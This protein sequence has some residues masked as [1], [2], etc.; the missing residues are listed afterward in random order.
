MPLALA[1]TTG[2]GGQGR[3]PTPIN[4]A[5]GLALT[6]V[7][8][9]GLRNGCDRMANGFTIVQQTTAGGAQVANSGS[10]IPLR[11]FP[12]DW[13]ISNPQFSSVTYNTNLGHTNYHSLQVSVTTRPMHGIS[14]QSTWTWAKSM[15]LPTSGYFDPA[16]RNLNFGAQ[17]INAHS[18]RMN[19]TIELPLGPNKLFFGNASGIF[20]RILERWQTSF[21]ANLSSGAPASLNPGQNHFYSASR[22]N[23]G[24]TW[25]NPKGEVEWNVVSPT[26]GR[27]TGSYYGSPS[28]F[29]GAR[30]PQCSDPA[31]VTQ[32][33]RM[34]TSLGGTNT[35]LM[36]A[37]ARRNADGTQ[38]EWLLTYPMPG[39]VGDSGNGNVMLFGQWSLD[40]NASKSF[41]ISESKTIQIRIDATNVLNHPVPNQPD[42]SALN[43]GSING[44]G[45]QRRQL[46]GQLRVSF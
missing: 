30:D 18:L 46:Q 1:P 35:C 19:G 14:T 7:S 28:P 40:M 31:I 10:A 27:I 24:L 12:E 33:D 32:G 36:T 2:T 15:Y 34:G 6:G 4:P 39:Q 3:Q 13:L 38:G 45:N 17:N 23:R 5:T 43:L 21:I 9:T 26:T 41:S 37:L 44:K 29:I 16:N 25:R 42:V 11:C 22:F 8:M 20:A